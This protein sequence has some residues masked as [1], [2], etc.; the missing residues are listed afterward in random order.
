MGTFPAIPLSVAE[1]GGAAQWAQ[2]NR[3]E[4]SWGRTAAGRWV[5]SSEVTHDG[6]TEGG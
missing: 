3:G 2:G 6:E 5:K 4:E 1:A